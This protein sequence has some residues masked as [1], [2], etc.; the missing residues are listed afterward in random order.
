MTIPRNVREELDKRD[1]LILALE[2]LAVDQAC[3][4]LALEAVVVNMA[5][6]GAI[7]TTDVKAR[8]TQEAKRFHQHFEG[9]GLSGF[10]ERAHRIA[11]ELVD[12]SKRGKASRKPVKKPR[13]TKRAK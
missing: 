13:T 10:V 8:I 9:E 1:E 2:M 5:Q 4:L 3:R 12:S 11:A 7:K 6:A